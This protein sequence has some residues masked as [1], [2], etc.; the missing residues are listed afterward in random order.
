ME[1]DAQTHVGIADSVNT[2]NKSFLRSASCGA[3]QYAED[4]IYDT[5]AIGAAE[6]DVLLVNISSKDTAGEDKNGQLAETV[7]DEEGHSGGKV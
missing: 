5:D 7:T 2:C 3:E 4:S 1:R 6:D